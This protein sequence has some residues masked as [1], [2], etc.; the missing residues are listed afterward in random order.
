MMRYADS[1]VRFMRRQYEPVENPAGMSRRKDY[2]AW[3]TIPLGLTVAMAAIFVPHLTIGGSYALAADYR[4]YYAAVHLF[5]N[6][7]NPYNQTTLIAA[8]QHIHAIPMYLNRREDGFVLLPFILWPLIPL[9]LL[10]YGVSFVVLEVLSLSG[11]IWSA[12][13]LARH[14]RWQKWWLVPLFG[15]LW[16]PVVWGRILGQLD[17]LILIGVV[18]TC[19]L[20]SSRR[21][22]F[23]GLALASVWVQPEL[24]WIAGVAL[25]VLLW[26]DRRAMVQTL[27]SFLAFSI[28][29]FAI[30]AFIP[31]GILA[32]WVAG[33]GVFAHREASHETD[34]LGLPAILQFIIPH[35]Y[36]FYG[37]SSVF[38]LSIALLGTIA[39][40]ATGAWLR[41]SG[42]LR[43]VPAGE[44]VLWQMF[45]PVGIWILVTPYGHPNNLVLL[46]PLVLLVIGSDARTIA[47]FPGQVFCLGAFIV[48]TEL[49][50]GTV[51]LTDLVPTATLILLGA[52][53]RTLW[54]RR[55]TNGP[56][57]EDRNLLTEEGRASPA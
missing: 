44:R 1:M 31:H 3:L 13:T 46:L 30:S 16:W 39:A 21:Y 41:L 24:G 36:K 20:V 6:G 40:I 18:G 26:G 57:S 33:G 12:A 29:V 35:D 53:A 2:R 22:Y 9:A 42:V 17:F 32:H 28:A 43:H 38:A 49:F 27:G 10:P 37:A 45:V 4:H 56:K 52:A 15:C 51:L 23:A 55:A 48:L 8:S 11:I 25:I 50:T 14:L 19:L 47:H 54:I 34:L 7:Q 5:L